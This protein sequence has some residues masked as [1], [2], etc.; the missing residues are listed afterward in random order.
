M[1]KEKCFESDKYKH[2]TACKA[3]YF[4]VKIVEEMSC[5]IGEE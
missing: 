5:H 3:C 2:E 4:R 1:L